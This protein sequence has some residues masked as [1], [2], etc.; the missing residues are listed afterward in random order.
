MPG[1]VASAPAAPGTGKQVTDPMRFIDPRDAVRWWWAIPDEVLVTMPEISRHDNPQV[2]PQEYDC[3]CVAVT[4][5]TDR[6]ARRGEKPFEMR[7]AVPCGK[8]G[9]ETRCFISTK[10]AG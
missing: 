4:R 7:L 1:V 3:G 8:D 2:S 9:C 10:K 5:I 6:E